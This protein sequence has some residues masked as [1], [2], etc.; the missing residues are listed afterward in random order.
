MSQK[1]KVRHAIFSFLVLCSISCWSFAEITDDELV[2]YIDADFSSYATS[3]I[4][5]ERGIQTALAEVDFKVKNKTLRIERLDHRGNVTRSKRNIKTYLDNNK[6]LVMYA[7]LHSP[8]LIKNRD[9]INRNEVLYL[10]PWAA[11]GPITRYLSR[12]NWI[13]RLSI[14]DTK[15]GEV[16]VSFAVDNKKLTK[17]CLVL[18]STGW[19]D[20][21]LRTMTRALEKRGLSPL[22]VLR[23]DWGTKSSSASAILE[24]CMKNGADSV[25][26]VANT[27]EGAYLI[28][29][30]SKIEDELELPVISHWGITGGDFIDRVGLSVLKDVELYVLQTRF[31]FLKE[32]LSKKQSQVL[33]SAISRY[34]D[35]SAPEDIQAATGFIHGYD[36]TLL[37]LEAL[38]QCDTEADIKVL[39][40]QL[41]NALENQTKPVEGLIKTY[42]HAFS[43]YS[44]KNPDAHEALTIEDIAIGVFLNSGSIKL[45]PWEYRNEN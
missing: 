29:A 15:A 28:D 38:S 1:M 8:P 20:S 32:S 40:R 16:I 6:A 3:S 35:Y 42:Q 10:D 27:N 26:L 24:T 25:Y 45:Y 7:G 41:R 12:Q 13:F 5:I 31:S 11:A 23:F 14:D 33:K 2:L 19:G 4:A 22:V 18:E 43:E 9:F 30:M 34:S 44:P 21:N 39:R 36:I 37:L 17:P